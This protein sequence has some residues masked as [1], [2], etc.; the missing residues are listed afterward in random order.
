MI[1]TKKKGEAMGKDEHGIDIITH[2][3]HAFA[4]KKSKVGNSI[5]EGE[6]KLVRDPSHRLGQG[7]IDETKTVVNYAKRM[8]IVSGGGSS[9]YVDGIDQKFGRLSEIEDFLIDDDFEYDLLK[10][11]I[12]AERR[13][14]VGH[15]AVP[16]DGYLMGVRYEDLKSRM[17]LNC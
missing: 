16:V 8:G 11:R 4:V 17:E 7:A 2:N 15:R 6:F 9:W 1:E 5:R 3:D 14:A 10:A 13:M 12:V